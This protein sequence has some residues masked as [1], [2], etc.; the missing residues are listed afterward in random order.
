MST[1]TFDGIEIPLVYAVEVSREIVGERARTAGGKMRQDV[2]T[3]KRAWKLQTRPMLRSKADALLNHLADK[4]YGAGQFLLDEFGGTPVTAY[5]LPESI[6]EEWAEFWS[7]GVWHNDGREL[8]LTVT[9][10]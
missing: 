9:E 5:I 1:A 2:V 8:E 6:R 10:Q 7:G 4:L 3:V